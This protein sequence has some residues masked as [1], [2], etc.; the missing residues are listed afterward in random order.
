MRSPACEDKP[1]L[2]E[3]AVRIQLLVQLYISSNGTLALDRIKKS[4]D[5]LERMM[6]K[7]EEF[8]HMQDPRE[9]NRS[10]EELISELEGITSTLAMSG[11]AAT[12]SLKE[13]EALDNR[14]SSD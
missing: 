3:L 12:E 1:S 5:K 6:D 10:L 4:Q 9:L 8:K 7:P 14:H 13:W 11:Q 2:E